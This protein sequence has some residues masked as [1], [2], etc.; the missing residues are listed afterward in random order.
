MH[1]LQRAVWLTDK[2]THP[3]NAVKHRMAGPPRQLLQSYIRA[4]VCYAPVNVFRLGANVHPI[5]K[6]RAKTY[7]GGHV[8]TPERRD[9]EQ[10][11]YL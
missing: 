2:L 1:A 10:A 8:C 9:T 4:S 3:K 11:A 7:A 6:P 5:R